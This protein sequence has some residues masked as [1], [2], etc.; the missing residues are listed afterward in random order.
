MKA[1]T[2]EVL[3]D[4]SRKQ[5]LKKKNKALSGEMNRTLLDRKEKEG[6]KILCIFDIEEN[7]T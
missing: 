7:R 1:L 4:L 3:E 5:E 2:P 6:S